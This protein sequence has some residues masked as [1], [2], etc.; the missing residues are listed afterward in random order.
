MDPM[1]KSYFLFKNLEAFI[2]T[3]PINPELPD[4]KDWEATRAELKKALKNIYVILAKERFRLPILGCGKPITKT[5]REQFVS[6]GTR[7]R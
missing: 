3:V 6:L 4:C 5:V 1:T 7:R 2:N